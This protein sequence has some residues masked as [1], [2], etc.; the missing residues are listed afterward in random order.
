M[1]RGFGTHDDPVEVR[2]EEAAKTAEELD[3]ILRPPTPAPSRVSIEDA[4]NLNAA[5]AEVLDIRVDMEVR[6]SENSNSNHGCSA[7]LRAVS[8][9][10]RPVFTDWRVASASLTACK[11]SKAVITG[12]TSPSRRSIKCW[13]SSSNGFAPTE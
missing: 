3:D 8:R 5:S 2:L 4:D 12:S 1:T 7:P 13:S 6:D 11:P 9:T 10:G